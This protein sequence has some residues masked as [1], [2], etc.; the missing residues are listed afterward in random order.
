ME[1]KNKIF[2][3]KNKVF[4][5]EELD[6]LKFNE[7]DAKMQADIIRLILEDIYTGTK[8][9][10]IDNKYVLKCLKLTCDEFDNNAHLPLGLLVK[11]ENDI[12]TFTFQ[13]RIG[14]WFIIGLLG[15]L[16]FTVVGATYSAFNFI[17]L[18]DLNKDI[19]GDGVADINID[20]DNDEEADINIDLNGDD[21]P[22]VNIDYKGNRELI[23]NIVSG[24]EI[25][26]PINVLNSEGV[27]I[28]NC[29]TNN[30]GWPD[31]NLDLTGDE[32]VTIDLDLNNDKKADMNLDMN[33][34]GKCDL[35]CDDNDDGVC[36]TY[37][38][39]SDDMSQVIISINGSSEI[40]GNTT[41]T[42]ATA[43][44]EIEYVDR[45][46]VVVQNILPDDMEGEGTVI[47]DKEFTVKNKSPY[48]VQYHL[49]WENVENTFITDNFKFKVECQ[50][51]CKT[52]PFTTAPKE[53][54]IF[55]RDIMIAPDQTHV[56]KVGFK[57]QGTNEPQ[58]DDKDK[59]FQGKIQVVY[60][61]E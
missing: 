55:I 38:L 44:L 53:D 30:D 16:L 51:R 59:L 15:A 23:F 35:H 28:R 36:D 43:T 57:L 20:I 27:C 19:D 7:L 4:K 41:T 61:G 1:E 14:M 6:V 8:E 48:Y 29:D 60:E 21:I 42:N 9:I 2:L 31:T 40:V 3:E 11:K 34:D 49:K 39:S 46:D 56:Y 18:K 24:D 58:N 17:K 47:P 32:K 45:S 13:K 33:G 10:D 54:E 12:M 25:L 26:N 37:C 5:D 52:L 22:D 50:E